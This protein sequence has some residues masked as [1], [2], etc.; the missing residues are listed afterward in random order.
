MEYFL[1]Q[2]FNALALGSV[3][4]LIALG[5]SVVYGVLKFLN[6]AHSEVFTTGVFTVYFVFQAG[7]KFNVPPELLVVL[8]LAASCLLSISIAILIERLAYRPLRSAPPVS[9]FMSAIGVSVILQIIGV[10]FFGAATRGIPDINLGVEPRLMAVILLIFSFIA[11]KYIVN[12]TDTGLRLRAVSENSSTAVLMGISPDKSIILAFGIGGLFSG[13]ASLVWALSYSTVHPQ[14]GFVIGMKCFIIAV[15]GSIGKLEGVFVVGIAL[16]FLETL[17]SA[18]LP[19][20]ISL[21][22]EPIVF[23]ILIMTLVAYP[24]GIFGSIRGEKV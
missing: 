3:Y 11:L 18:Y 7:L 6:F 2:S 9:V 23:S 12:F 14:M 4:A 17:I 19:S 10:K 13:V 21:L 8:A 1:D 16:G 20:E 22:K 5:F 15:L 24:Q